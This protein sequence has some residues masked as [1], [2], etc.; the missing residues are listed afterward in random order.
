MVVSLVGNDFADSYKSSSTL[1]VV[2]PNFTGG[3]RLQPHCVSS[4]RKFDI[5]DEAADFFV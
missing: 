3:E 5:N 1:S 4:Q 2:Q